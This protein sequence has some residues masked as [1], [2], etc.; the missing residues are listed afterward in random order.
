MEWP[1]LPKI[2]GCEAS[3]K[4]TALSLRSVMSL[5]TARTCEPYRESSTYSA[6]L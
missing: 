1:L 2:V 3:R 5:S 4:S 6:L